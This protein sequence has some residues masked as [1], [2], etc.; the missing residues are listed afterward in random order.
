LGIFKSQRLSRNDLL[1]SLGAIAF[2]LHIW[3]IINI[4]IVIPAWLLRSSIWEL[5][6]AISY[7]LVDALLESCI[8]WAGFIALSYMLPKK[9]F[10]DRFV[11][12][13]SIL[14]WLL[15]AWVMLAQF[16]Y[17]RII[18]WNLE[19]IL[20]GL[21]LVAS[22][23][24]LVYWL[25]QKYGRFENRIKKLAQGLILLVYFYMLFDLL[26]LALIIIRNV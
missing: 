23:I 5:A 8:L 3:A 18:Q 11:A 26:G 14:G 16:I 1:L 2:P 12:L 21:L 24:G 15:T 25:V 6:G 4:L 10:A 20:P 13:S 19:Q 17:L 7:P 22:S 9:W